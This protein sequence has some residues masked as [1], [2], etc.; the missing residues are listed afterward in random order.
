MLVKQFQKIVLLMVFTV[1]KSTFVI[2]ISQKHHAQDLQKIDIYAI[3]ML[4]IKIA[5]MRID[6]SIYPNLTRQIKNVEML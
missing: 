3:G 1:L 5:K 2:H 6:V 4:T